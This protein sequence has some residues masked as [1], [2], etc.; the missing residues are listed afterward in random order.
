MEYEFA[1]PKRR[2]LVEDDSTDSAMQGVRK[3]AFRPLASGTEIPVISAESVTP[4]R[5]LQFGH[6]EEDRAQVAALSMKKAHRD[7]LE[8]A[9]HV[10][11]KAEEEKD[12]AAAKMEE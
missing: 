10:A 7:K 12:I 3:H 4:A 1:S 6:S 8:I 9:N 11:E 2:K 5:I